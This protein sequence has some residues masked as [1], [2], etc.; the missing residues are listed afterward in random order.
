MKKKKVILK[1]GEYV[2]IKGNVEI[3]APN[4]KVNGIWRGGSSWTVKNPLIRLG[5]C[6]HK[7]V[8]KN[9][10]KNFSGEKVSCKGQIV[11]SDCGMVLKFGIVEDKK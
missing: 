3:Y 8:K 5:K 1:K 2:R 6:I 9:W 7:P 10:F 11:C 4:K